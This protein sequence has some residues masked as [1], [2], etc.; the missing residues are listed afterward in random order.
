MAAVC[1][2]A[3]WKASAST[4]R[5]PPLHTPQP[6]QQRWESDDGGEAAASLRLPCRSQPHRQGCC[7]VIPLL[8]AARSNAPPRPCQ[9]THVRTHGCVLRMVCAY[10][11]K[12]PFLPGQDPGFNPA[13]HWEQAQWLA[14]TKQVVLPATA[15]NVAFAVL[16]LATL[17]LLVL[18]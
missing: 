4:R 15:P 8:P 17:V 2:A 18:W 5:H 9:V 11:Q 13:N 1:P 12:L 14:Y 10:A 7:C 3:T 6:D 16:P